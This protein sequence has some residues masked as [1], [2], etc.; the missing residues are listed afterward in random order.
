[1]DSI[2]VA[3]ST[4]L[5]VYSKLPGLDVLISMF[6][7]IWIPPEVFKESTADPT[8]PGVGAILSAVESGTI[9][10]SKNFDINEIPEESRIKIHAGET[11]AI[12]LALR[13]PS[14]TLVTDD[15]VAKDEAIKLGLKVLRNGA[16]LVRAKEL[17]LVEL[18]AP[19]IDYWNTE[20]KFPVGEDTKRRL[21]AMAGEQYSPP[22]PTKK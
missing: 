5:I 8:L 16:L 20:G 3:D 12:A 18:I 9:K 4:A 17:G 11:E 10:L 7:E 6:D 1:M 22:A 14:K 19:V 2:V 21:L 13:C 15:N